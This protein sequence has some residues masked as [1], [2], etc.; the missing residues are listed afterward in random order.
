M[1]TLTIPDRQTTWH[2]A[3]PAPRRLYHVTNTAPHMLRWIVAPLAATHRVVAAQR[4]RAASGPSF[5]RLVL[6]PIDGAGQAVVLDVVLM[7][8][9]CPARLGHAA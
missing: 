4:R 9:K 8:S 5:L 7:R 2:V 3:E 6:D 1:D